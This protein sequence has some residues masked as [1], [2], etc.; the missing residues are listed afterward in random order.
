MTENRY[1]KYLPQ[2][3]R[4]WR[5]FQQLARV[6]G[7][8]LE[9]AAQAKQKLEENQ[10]LLS[11]Q[12]DGLLRTARIMGFL[13]AEGLET[14]ELRKEILTRWNNQSPYTYFHLLDWL[15]ACLGEGSYTLYL[16]RERYTLRL[17]LQL[18]VKE[19]KD[20]LQ[21]RLRKI[22]PA[23]LILE[24]L[25]QTNTYGTVGRLTH[26]ALQKKGLTYGQIPTEDLRRA[27]R[28]E[29]TVA[30]RGRM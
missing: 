19:K 29:K 4:E 11:A 20:F 3:E 18:W 1:S 16:D 28:A 14:E 12:R 6:E 25:L 8:M 23:N 15:E 13:G 17:L 26:G 5:E 21:S 2:Q 30:Q 27:D 7:Q 22:L 9:E 10:W 24:V